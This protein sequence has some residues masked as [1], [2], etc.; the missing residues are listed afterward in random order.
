VLAALAPFVA[1][2]AGWTQVSGG[3]AGGTVWQGRIPN[4]VVAWDTRPSAVY[5]PPHFDPLRRY[6]VVY[7]LHG[8]RGSP[9]SFWDSL[10]LATVADSLISSGRAAPFIAVMP[11]AGP[12]VHPGRGEWAGVWEEYV[13]RDVVPWVDA[14][15]PTLPGPRNRAIEGLSAGGFGAI[16][17]GLRHP[18]LFGTLGA[19]GAYFAPVFHDGPFARATSRVL[20]AHDPMLLVRREAAALKRS[21]ARFYVSSDG[22][23]GVVLGRWTL[24]FTA[25][26]SALRL[27]HELWLEPKPTQGSFWQ[28]TLPS[29]LAYAAAGFA[30]AASA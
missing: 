26:L 14:N 29:A 16:D 12:L 6:P 15:L 28:V 30:S 22:G 10:R 11:V 24:A 5:L 25:E 23:H 4:T 2:L 9:S 8:M 17:I 21:G 20:R 1:A 13:V 19:W 7:L 18:G 3:P 27:P